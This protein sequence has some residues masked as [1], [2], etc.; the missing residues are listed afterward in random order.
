L[1]NNRK[2]AGKAV[3]KK[4]NFGRKPETRA[5]SFLAFFAFFYFMNLTTRSESENMEKKGRVLLST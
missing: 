1:H 4:T 5:D 2:L 3:R